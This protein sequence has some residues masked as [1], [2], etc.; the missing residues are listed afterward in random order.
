MRKIFRLWL[1]LTIGLIFAVS[2]CAFGYDAEALE[3]ISEAS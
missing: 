2:G 1:F 3:V